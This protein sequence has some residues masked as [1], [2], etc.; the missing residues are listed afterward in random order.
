MDSL[1]LITMLKSSAGSWSAVSNFVVALFFV[2]GGWLAL[3]AILNFKNH[4]DGKCGAA[5]PIFQTIISSLMIAIGR[6]IPILSETLNNNNAQFKPSELLTAIPE[7]DPLGIGLAFTSILLFVQMLGVIAIFRGFIMIYQATNRG[8]GSGLVG[9]AWT[10]VVGG[11]LAVNIQLTISTLAL[12][13]YPSVNLAF[14][15]F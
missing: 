8:E 2:V 14:L 1:T 13:F 7:T 11:V 5:K 15:G 12:T 6:F 4:S 3:T 9:K 10:H